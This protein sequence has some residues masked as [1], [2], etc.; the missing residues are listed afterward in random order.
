MSGL[1]LDHAWRREKRILVT[2]AQ[3][4]GSIAV[5]RSLGQAGYRVIACSPKLDALGF[6]SS[7]CA[8]S[9]VQPDDERFEAW[10]K[11]IIGRE[12]IDLVIPS[13][14]FL[15]RIRPFFSSLQPLMALPEGEETVY[16]A[17]S[18]FDLFRR[19][20]D[21]GLESALPPCLLVESNQPA[22]AEAQLSS[23]GFPV[24]IKAD[25]VSGIDRASGGVF[26]GDSPE[27]ARR[28]IAEKS[29]QYS[30]LLVQGYVPGVGI[31]VFL[32]RWQGRFVAEFMHRRLH[33]DPH[34]GGVSSYRCSWRNKEMLA[35]AKRRMECM[36][37]Q[38][39]GMLEYRW[40]PED[41]RFYL[42]EFNSRFWGSL[43]LA[44]FAGVD[45]PRYLADLFFGHP[46]S[47][48]TDYE[49]IRSR[50]VFPGEVGHVMSCVRDRN[51]ALAYRLW[52]P[53][54][55]FLLGLHPGVRADLIFPGDSKLYFIRAARWLRD[56][57]R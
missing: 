49:D 20:K 38:G 40:N 15:L 23:L 10:L 56:M 29:L 42:L 13:E 2:E 54:E 18:K 35:D 41:G 50:L 51:L 52:K 47:S 26:R 48:V 9:Y 53:V 6:L 14:S 5:I 30:R 1:N 24:F 28:L 16:A 32:I 17:F 22:P 25:A 57:L 12:R 43:H 4:I 27:S 46:V 31:G 7:Y 36:N 33:E 44:L 55:F 11:E 19:S 21:A 39:V 37:W 8:A 34:T 3:A 45:F